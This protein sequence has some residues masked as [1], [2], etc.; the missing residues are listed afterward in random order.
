[1][2]LIMDASPTMAVVEQSVQH[3][4]NHTDVLAGWASAAVRAHALLSQTMPD[5][6]LDELVEAAAPFDQAIVLPAFFFG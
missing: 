6:E 5:E 1:M 2:T 3:P 4:A